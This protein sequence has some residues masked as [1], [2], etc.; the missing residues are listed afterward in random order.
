MYIHVYTCTYTCTVLVHYKKTNL[1]PW[2]CMHIHMY[3]VLVFFC[4]HSVYSQA[5]C[6]PHRKRQKGKVM[7]YVQYMYKYS[8][9]VHMHE[10]YLLQTCNVHIH[11]HVYTVQY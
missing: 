1:T 10:Y 2:L 9:G 8:C 4:S 7:G 11:V 6:I 5:K 3:N